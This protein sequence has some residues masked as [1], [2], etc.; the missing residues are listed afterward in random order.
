[1]P[2]LQHPQA[3]SYLWLCVLQ[4]LQ[5]PVNQP[6]ALCLQDA[7]LAMQQDPALQPAAT[8]VQHQPGMATGNMHAGSTAQQALSNLQGL[9]VWVWACC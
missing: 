6:S 9:L 8:Q 2:H 3:S 1:M 4:E 7:C 5:H